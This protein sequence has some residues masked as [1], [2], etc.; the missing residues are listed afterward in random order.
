[1][2]PKSGPAH[3]ELKLGSSGAFSYRPDAGFH[4]IDTFTYRASDGVLDSDPATVTL[5]VD[6][7]PVAA[8]DDFPIHARPNIF[9]YK[10]P[11]LLANDVDA[12]GDPLAVSITTQPAHGK[13]LL[14]PITG[15]YLYKPDA[16]DFI[17]TDSF[18]YTVSDGL[19]ESN[20]T[21]VTLNMA[22]S[23]PVAVDDD[24]QIHARPNIFAYKMPDMLAND[25]DA[26]GDPLTVSIVTGPA[27]GRL[28]LDPLDGGYLYKPDVPDFIGT[29]SFTYIATDGLLQ[30]NTA[31]VTLN[32]ADSAPVAVDDVFPIH[33]RPNIFAY[34]MPDMLANDVD[35]DGD[36]LTV[37]IVTG[38]AH[39]RLLLD[40]ID[41]GY[42]YKPDVPDFIGTDSF[43]YIATDGLLQSNTA[44]V[45]LNIADSAPVAVDDVFP[46]HAR[47]NVSQYSLPDIRENDIDVDGDQLSVS[48]VTGPIHGRLLLDPFALGDG[49]YAYKPDPGFLGTDSFTYTVSDGLLESNV[50]TV[51]LNIADSAPIAVND[52]FNFRPGALAFVLN[53]LGNDLDSDGDSLN[54]TNV[55]QPVHGSFA[56][57]PVVDN[58]LYRP[59][60]GFHGVDSFTYVATDGVLDSNVAS[61]TL[62]IDTAPVA[63]DDSYAV[64]PG[65]L[66]AG[67]SV[68]GND[69]D[70][71][72]DSLTARVVA[73]PSHASSF[74]LLPNGTFRYLPELGFRG[75]D[76]FTYVANDG[77]VDSN[78]ATVTLTVD[79]QPVAADDS[80]VV[81]PDQS[82]TITGACQ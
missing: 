15:G 31:T 74:L 36:P 53:V 79:R 64:T 77:F 10:V 27:H 44:T 73:G 16:P 51:T 34:K 52:S 71:E 32:I 54:V 25:V 9:A 13:V 23:A 56:F 12:D 82:I 81:R 35:A 43:T 37:S 68:L 1:V 57:D 17:G 59:V 24:F 28:L 5:I 26:D 14:D 80:Y 22:D 50:A 48:I 45:T 7:A 18:T 49:P 3:G 65:Q 67:S 69:S 63:E 76:S 8:D 60:R 19:L 41:G 75:T 61:V 78:L 30:S 2:P 29:D 39:G 38:P 21:T 62:T 11:D 40:S 33:A 66:F 20:V 42:L 46:I 55:T 70:A 58:Y 72:S 47:P 6:N 4:G